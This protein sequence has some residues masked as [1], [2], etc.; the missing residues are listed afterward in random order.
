MDNF[1]IL[2]SEGGQF[3]LHII[4]IYTYSFSTYSFFYGINGHPLFVTEGL[5]YS[6]VLNLSSKSSSNMSISTVKL[7]ITMLVVSTILNK[8]F[9]TFKNNF[10]FF[11]L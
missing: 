6:L 2:E 4:L 3:P 7:T 11:L 8:L 10:I 1:V 9:K 5:G